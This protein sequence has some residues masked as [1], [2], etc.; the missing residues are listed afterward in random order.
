[1]RFENNHTL[2]VELVYNFS[3]ISESTSVLRIYK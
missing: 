3:K 1:M 2:I